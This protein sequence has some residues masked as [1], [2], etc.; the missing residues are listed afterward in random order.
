M[1]ELLSLIFSHESPVV[2]K[3]S[4]HLL[5]SIMTNN[6]QVQEFA[7]KSG[8]LNLVGQFEREQSLQLKDAVFGSL[9]AWIKADNFEGKRRFINDTNGLDFLKRLLCDPAVNSTFNIRLKKRVMNLINDLVTNDDGIFEEQPFFV[10][11]NF[12]QDINVLNTLAGILTGAN[13]KNMQEL[14]YRD[15]VLLILF[16]LHQRKPD[17]VGPLFTPIL[18]QHRAAIQALISSPQADADLKEMLA[19]E[20]KRVDNALAAPSRP[21]VRNFEQETE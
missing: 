4:C 19:E 16:R 5:T 10:R 20:L 1:T 11:D 18:Y 2:R 14:V 9:A 7:S 12:C 6:R 8:A 3:T 21:F 15:T 13:L 17:L